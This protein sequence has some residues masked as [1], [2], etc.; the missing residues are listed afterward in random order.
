MTKLT[1]QQGVKTLNGG[2][3]KGHSPRRHNACVSGAWDELGTSAIEEA[4]CLRKWMGHVLV[5]KSA[6]RDGS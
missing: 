1:Q 2:A 4:L 6:T 3:I 5:A